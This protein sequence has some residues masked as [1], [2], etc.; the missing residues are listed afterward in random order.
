MC[1]V[2]APSAA[3]GKVHDHLEPES[4]GGEHPSTELVLEPELVE[5]E[6]TV[7]SDL[8]DPTNEATGESGQF[9]KSFGRLLKV[10][11]GQQR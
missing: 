4:A 2:C 5:E 3:G 7:I 11:A 6:S 9:K 8:P 1:E 10:Q